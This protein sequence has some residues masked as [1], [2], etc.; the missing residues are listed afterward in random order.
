MTHAIRALRNAFFSPGFRL[1][2][3]RFS[4]DYLRFAWR[5]ARRWGSTEPG[6]LSVLGYR[7]DYFN[8]SHTLFLVHEIFVNAAYD[9]T[10]PNTRPRIVD[11][12]ANIGMA[13]LFFKAVRPEAEVIAF[14][15]HPVTF[16]RLLD[17]IHSN[18]LHNVHAENAAVGGTDGTGAFYSQPSDHGSLTGS[19]DRSWGGDER[20]E[21]RTVRLSGWIRE[22]VDFLKIDVE[23]AEY[24][25]IDDLIETDAIRWVREAAIEYHDL[26][27]KPGRLTRMTTAL[28]AAGFHIR[29]T[30][31]DART[32]VGLLRARRK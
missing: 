9:F 18:G 2:G 16:A 22:P 23:G 27:T 30:I 15:P 26:E 5:A 3:L 14:E 4:R 1:F 7:L 19:V 29:V 21:I 20:L 8:Q 17:T 6:S 11:C 31:A 28:E 12:G 32:R 24:D 25:V 10:T 13:V